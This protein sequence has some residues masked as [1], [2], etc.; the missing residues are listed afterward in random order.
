MTR[1]VERPARDRPPTKSLNK[2][3]APGCCYSHVSTSLRFSTLMEIFLTVTINR[4]LSR[5]LIILHTPAIKVK[6][7]IHDRGKFDV[8]YDVFYV[9]I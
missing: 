4:L 6:E 1:I 3:A 5:I 7:L 8:F 2:G 9:E